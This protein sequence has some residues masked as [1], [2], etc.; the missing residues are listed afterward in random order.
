MV[1]LGYNEITRICMRTARR[2]MR[3]TSAWSI[4][5]SNILCY[6]VYRMEIRHVYTHGMVAYVAAIR[7]PGR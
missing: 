2:P 4:D 3:L 7:F 1:S 6:I 5:K